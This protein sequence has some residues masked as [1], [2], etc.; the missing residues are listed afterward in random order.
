[1]RRMHTLFTDLLILMPMKVKEMRNCADDAAKVVNQ[2][3]VI[4]NFYEICSGHERLHAGRIAAT[5]DTSA[6]L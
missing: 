1:M 5:Q 4:A 2:M 6:S 3:G